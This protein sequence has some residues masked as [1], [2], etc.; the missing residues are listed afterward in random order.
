MDLPP[1]RVQTS[2]V[3]PRFTPRFEFGKEPVLL[4]G[5]EQP[6]P[7]SDMQLKLYYHP[8]ASFCW[9]ALIALYENGTPFEPIIVDLADASSRENFAKVWPLAKFPVLRDETRGQTIA[10]ATRSSNT[11]MPSI[12]A[13]R[14][15]SRPTRSARGRRACGIA[16]STTTSTSRCRRS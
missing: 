12:R 11:S 14:A 2:A 7:E 4:S 6:P 9:K 8:L 1:A 3:Y 5:S 10:E 16:S 15:S 13:R